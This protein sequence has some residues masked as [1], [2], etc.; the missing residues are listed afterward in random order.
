M[1]ATLPE[2]ITIRP[3]TSFA[4]MDEAVA[5]QRQIWNDPT[6]VIYQHMLISLVRSG[7]LLMGA[8]KDKL[9]VGFVLSYL[10]IESPEADRPAMANLKMVSQRMAVLPEYRGGGIAYALKLAQRDYAVKQGIRLITWT[11]D[12]L[13]S[14]NAHLN[15]RKLGVTVQHY[16][17]NYYG[18]KPSPLVSL[19]QSDRL[20]ADWRVTNARVD[21]RLHGR[22]GQLRLDQ[23]LSADT[24]KIIN[25]TTVGPDNLPRP[26]APKP[27]TGLLA[28]TEIPANF[29]EILR[30]DDVL[31]REWRAHSR[32]VLTEAFRANY[33]VTDFL[34]V[35]YEGRQRSFYVF[36]AAE[37]LASFS[38][39]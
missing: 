22:R 19:D 15:I 36:S 13:N 33:I 39:N 4:E 5:L 25:P 11:F 32:E 17:R 23:Y 8:V 3:L 27:T 34:H 16:E 26:G 30:A 38:T 18:I 31:A 35:D 21:Q 1:A 10:G 20:V 37:A 9:L 28:L 7:G 29:D 14:R 24:V 12:P 2:G 6:T